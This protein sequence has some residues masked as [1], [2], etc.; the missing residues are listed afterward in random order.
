MIQV[1]SPISLKLGQF[2]V[3]ILKLKI[4]KWF[5]FWNFPGGDRAPP[6]SFLVGRAEILLLQSPKVESRS[7]KVMRQFI[8]LLNTNKYPYFGI[9]LEKSQ[10]IW[11]YWRQPGT[12]EIDSCH[13]IRHEMTK[14]LI[15]RL[16][17]SPMSN[18]YLAN[19]L[20]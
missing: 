20:P 16:K 10:F 8:L 12:S 9:L 6:L 4:Q 15:F 1:I 2:K 7:G 19:D 14:Y 13:A 18:V 17:K 11:L 3:S 5:A